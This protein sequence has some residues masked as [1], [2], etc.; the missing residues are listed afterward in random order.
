MLA[1][2]LERALPATQRAARVA[3]MR[4]VGRWPLPRYAGA[5][6]TCRATAPG[7][8]QLKKPT[9]TSKALGANRLG[10]STKPASACQPQA[11]SV[12]CF[13]LGNGPATAA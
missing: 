10:W 2:G 1:A 13:C 3:Y 8:C 6:R 9:N 5:A 11:T 4:A 12:T 7:S